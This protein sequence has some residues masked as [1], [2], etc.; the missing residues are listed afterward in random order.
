M[1]AL[2]LAET[3]AAQRQTKEAQAQT[4]VDLPSR[5]A[6]LGMSILG[7][8][9]APK[10]LVITPCKCTELGNAFGSSKVLEELRLP[11]D[12]ATKLTRRYLSGC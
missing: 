5:R 3:E 6:P 4:E 10:A 2:V 11:I 8:Q 12:K 7:N 1:I 9:Q